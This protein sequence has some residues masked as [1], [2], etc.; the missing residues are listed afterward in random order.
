MNDVRLFVVLSL[1]LGCGHKWFGKVMTK[2]DLFS[3]ECPSC[4]DTDSFCSFVPV[5]Y[6]ETLQ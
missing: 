2:T 4:G 1:C 5:N 6:E 3:L